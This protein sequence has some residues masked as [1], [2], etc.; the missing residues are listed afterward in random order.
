VPTELG[1]L[2]VIIDVSHAVATLQIKK[3]I[4]AAT[5][6]SAISSQGESTATCL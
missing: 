5:A 6:Y 4:K 3:V 2:A 1:S